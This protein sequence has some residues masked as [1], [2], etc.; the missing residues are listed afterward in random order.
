M[1]LSVCVA[2]INYEIL[3]EATLQGT[4]DSDGKP[5]S[6][7][8]QDMVAIKATMRLGFLVVKDDAFAAFKNG[9][10]AMGELDVESVAGTTGNTVITVSPKLSAVTSWFT[11]LPQAPLQVLRTMMIYRNGR[12]LA[13]VMKLLRQTVTR[14]QLRKLPQTAKREVGQCRRCKW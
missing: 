10:P 1:P 7:A 14:L 5:L 8:E 6:L 4:L 3:T 12:S 2:G 13:V 11:R 9:V